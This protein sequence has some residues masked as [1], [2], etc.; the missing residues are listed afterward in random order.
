MM[1]NTMKYCWL[2]VWLMQAVFVQ[3]VEGSS[4]GKPELVFEGLDRPWAMAFISDTELLITEKQG[5]VLKLN[6]KTNKLTELAVIDDVYSKGQA[7]LMDIAPALDFEQSQRVYF[8]YAKAHQDKAVTALATA[9]IKNN[10]LTE[11]KDLLVTDSYSGTNRHFGSRIAL[12]KQA[13]YFTVGER[14]VRE[15][16]QDL[17]NHAGKVLRLN[18]DGT[19]FQDNPFTNTANAKA[20]IYSF[21]HRNPQGITFDDKGRLWV[22]EH[23]PRGGDEL[24]LVKAGSNYGWPEVS[25]GKEYWGPLA[26]GVEHKEGMVDSVYSYVPSIAP[27]DL[28]FYQGKFYISALNGKHLNVLN[29]GK[30]NNFVES[31]LFEELKERIRAL[32]LADD[33]QLYFATD[34]GKVYRFKP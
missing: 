2:L 16:A 15:N 17:S 3:A 21:G 9:V 31:R 25:L 8:T 20:E 27:S 33:G 30:G 4:N 11:L 28:L 1:M 12:A 24:N 22:M 7:G 5:K 34:S 13:I 19:A 10:Q 6:L 29:V 32:A 26:V 18:N 23:G 14:G